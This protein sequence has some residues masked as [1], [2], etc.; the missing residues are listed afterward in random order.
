MLKMV[1]I[2]EAEPAD[3]NYPRKS[4]LV[5]EADGSVR[6]LGNLPH[7]YAFRPFTRED[8]ITLASHIRR[9]VDDGQCG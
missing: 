4:T 7:N 2:V 6:V 1:S 3:A 8:A 9:A 5:L